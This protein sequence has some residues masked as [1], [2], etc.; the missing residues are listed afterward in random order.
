MSRE[1]EGEAKEQLVD[2]RQHSGDCNDSFGSHRPVVPSLL[3]TTLVISRS[4]LKASNL[5]MYCIKEH[6]DIFLLPEMYHQISVAYKL[7]PATPN[8]YQVTP[9]G[10][11]TPRLGTTDGDATSVSLSLCFSSRDSGSTYCCC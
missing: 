5:F 1:K 2:V 11:P 7:S 10:V 9:S 8:A 3:E 6:L 4:S